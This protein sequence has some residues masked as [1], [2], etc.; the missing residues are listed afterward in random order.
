VSPSVILVETGRARRPN[1]TAPLE[2][3]GFQVLSCLTIFDVE[4]LC[5]EADLGVVILELESPLVSNRVLRD[6][7]RKRPAMHLIGISDRLFHPELKDA[8]SHYI[9][10]C[11]CDP[12]DP[13]ELIYLVKSIFSDAATSEQ[14]RAEDALEG[15]SLTT[16]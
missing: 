3:N 11:L 2:A 4:T 10:A 15:P 12:I 9:Y 7:K 1:L 6:L 14:N 16:K 5:H 13:D 8:I